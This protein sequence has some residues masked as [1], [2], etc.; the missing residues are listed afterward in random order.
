MALSR[1][2]RA[3]VRR[4]DPAELRQ[5]LL[6]TRGLLVHADGHPDPAVERDLPAT[7]RYRQRWVDCGRDSCSTCPHGPY[8]YA[9]WREDGRT[10][11]RYIG[12]HLPGEPLDPVAPDLPA[13]PARGGPLG[14]RRATTG[15]A[16]G[17][18]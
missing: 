8:W 16:A 18:R 14:G 7:L 15:P 12:R 2:L 4:L 13:D 5:L 9:F 6:F 3:Q 1:E 11:K 10:R 17:G